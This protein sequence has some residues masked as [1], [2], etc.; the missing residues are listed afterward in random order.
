MKLEQSI[1]ELKGIGEKN[2]ALFHKLNI[3]TIGELLFHFPREYR[4]FPTAGT[5]HD[6][7]SAVGNAAVFAMVQSPPEVRR[8]RGMSLL[9]FRVIDRVGQTAT[10][11]FFNMPYL[12][13]SIKPDKTYIFYGQVHWKNK[14]A[15]LSHPKMYSDGEY[16]K[17]E[18]Q[19]APVYARTKG[20]T[21]QA[22]HKHCMNALQSVD[23]IE[24][25]L[26][27]H[28]LSKH[29][30]LPIKESLYQ[31]HA[32]SDLSEA[33][34]ARKRFAYEE[35]LLFL[36]AVKSQRSN[37][38]SLSG[39]PMLETADVK[40]LTEQLPYE[41]TESQKQAY[42]QIQTDMLGERCMNRLLQGDVGSG[43]T[44]VA[45]MALLLCVSNGY[46]G[47][48]MA[49]TEVLATQHMETVLAMT[50]T[51][52][53]PFK[54]VLLTGS[55]TAK[56]KREIYAA[57]ESGECNL[58]I[59]THAVIQDNVIF[60]NLALV[61]TDEQ[62]RFGVKQRE[63]LVSKG[64]DVHTIVMSATPIP[65]SLALI[66]YGDLDIT[67]M[68][69]LPSQRL[70]IKNCVVNQNYRQTAYKFMQ[71]EISKGYQVY[72]ICPMA[73]PGIMEDLENVVDYS[74]YIRTFFSDSV[75]IAYLHG[76][77]K[78]KQKADIMER[79]S[80]GQIDILVS[81]TVIEVGIN[82]PN[83]T[84]MLV[85]NAERFGLATLHQIRGRVGRGKQQS[86][87]IF[88]ETEEKT[89][90]NERLEILNHSNDGFEI[91]SE[92]LKLRGPGDFMGIEQSGT[93]HF[94]FADIYQDADMLKK[95]SAD[96][97]K[98]LENDSLLLEESHIPLKK[99]MEAYVSSGYMKIL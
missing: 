66:L 42:A 3:N 17:L 75:Q 7:K 51:Y 89:R 56:E 81:T 9:K 82:V 50:Q 53:L 32:P 19:L 48:M 54:P 60:H 64:T 29:G 79:F 78:P 70:P 45:M 8:V 23:N 34:Q 77:M 84:V 27:K 58:I 91:A 83:A 85:E 47:A 33:I 61:I 62:H 31:L 43:K 49:P 40:R 41:L 24:E 30:F 88:M 69:G 98:I 10:V 2:A 71:N 13:N 20:L 4:K 16:E 94:R 52:G 18:G 67:E 25:Y 37:V 63:K 28:L 90:K 39:H 5:L 68:K 59:G 26:P 97:S 57:I 38:K 15:F 22:F 65:R 93:F 11:T 80:A 55:Q 36:L 44:I 6:A 35:F 87:C 46:Q 72:V 96:V 21:D 12:K 14:E 86:Y 92:D 99:R 73:E 74:A 1:M 95:A 76:K